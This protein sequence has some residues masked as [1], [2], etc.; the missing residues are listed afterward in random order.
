MGN[1]QDLILALEK[2]SDNSDHWNLI[3][4]QLAEMKD[5]FDSFQINT[6]ISAM[7]YDYV[8]REE[9]ERR[10]RWGIFAPMIEMADG[11]VSPQPL[12]SLSDEQLKL[13]EST[14]NITKNPV[15]L[16]RI[17]DLLWIRH[18]S[19][20][21]HLFARHSIESYLKLSSSKWPSIYKTECL[22]RA[23]EI[24][25]EL[26]DERLI[27]KI[28]S[29]LINLANENL[30][31]AEL[32]PG[33]P[34]RIIEAL[35]R[36]PKKYRCFD[37]EPIINSC[38]QKYALNSNI[39][40]T[41]LE[42]K[43][44]RAFT[45]EE[46][47]SIRKDRIGIWRKEAEKSSGLQKLFYLNKAEE[48]ARLYGFLKE[49][50]EIIIDLQSIPKEEL[51]PKSFEFTTTIPNE[52]IESSINWFFKDEKWQDCLNRFGSY[53]PP[54]GNYPEN[55]L[56]V[57][58]LIKNYPVP[59]L[60]SKVILDDD[61]FPIRFVNT[62][63][64]HFNTQ[65]VQQ[66]SIRIL[67][68]GL[69]AVEIINRLFKKYNDITQDELTK[70]FFTPII[71]EDVARRLAYAI[72]LYCRGDY[73][74]SAHI[75]L[76]KI[77]LIFRTITGNLGLSVFRPPIAERPGGVISLGKIFD[78]LNGRIDESWRRYFRNLLS[79]PLGMNIR[80]R[81]LHGRSVSATKQEAALLIH[82]ICNLRLIQ[83]KK[84]S[85]T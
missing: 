55:V 45:K 40:D 36:I 46:K 53:G 77:E 61:N 3:G 10:E 17:N 67:F 18:F 79:D 62:E 38:M 20:E 23:L 51:E 68:F 22:V 72:C 35:E 32:Q 29:Y 47:D 83:I 34:L 78:S 6:L 82:V 48:Y 66:E 25:M 69:F 8:E 16:S 19:D 44:R 26:S 2:I 71:P 14:T 56:E 15:I 54:S 37:V 27:S 65:L 13:L 42:I 39:I 41:I 12:S 30:A 33:V 73:D 50:K 7:L 76:T 31:E 80:N 70:Y 4:I 1:L 28:S 63:D 60:I 64:E 75:L 85:T 24:S 59:F 57:E 49:E 81:I 9:I 74:G 52:K 21:P 5:D 84:D 11:R 43:I 58:N